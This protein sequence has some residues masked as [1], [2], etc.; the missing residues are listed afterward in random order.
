MR[1][2]DA[3]KKSGMLRA[4]FKKARKDIQNRATLRRLIVELID[5]QNL[6][7]PEI[8]AQEIANDL[9][10]ALESFFAIAAELT[11]K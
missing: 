8:L 10:T 5:S 1:V 6:P 4:I 7:D 11:D 2:F 3:C 9:Q